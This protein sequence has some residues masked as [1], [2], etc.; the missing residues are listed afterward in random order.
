MLLLPLPMT[1]QFHLVK[2]LIATHLG[3]HYADGL[4]MWDGVIDVAIPLFFFCLALLLLFL[5]TASRHEPGW[6]D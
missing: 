2:H 3:S 5:A 4:E 6:D 1:I